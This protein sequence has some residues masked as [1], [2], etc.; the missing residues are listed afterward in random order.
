MGNA[1]GWYFTDIETHSTFHAAICT[2][3]MLISCKSLFPSGCFAIIS[4]LNTNE[5][6]HEILTNSWSIRL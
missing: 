2:H 1:P 6:F 5:I 3:L 4:L